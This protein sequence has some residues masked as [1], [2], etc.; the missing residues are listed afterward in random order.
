MENQVEYKYIHIGV[1]IPDVR[2]YTLSLCKKFTSACLHNVEIRS[3]VDVYTAKIVDDIFEK[4]RWNV[5]ELKNPFHSYKS[6]D[7][8]YLV[9]RYSDKL[10]ELIKAIFDLALFIN[11]YKWTKK[12]KWNI[13]NGIIAE[14]RDIDTCTETINRRV[15]EIRQYLRKLR[16][17]GKKSL[18]TRLMR[19]TQKCKPLIDK[20]FS[21]L[22]NY[23]VFDAYSVQ[24]NVCMEKA[25]NVLKKFFDQNTSWRYADRICRG[26]GSVYLFVRDS[27]FGIK[28]SNTTEYFN[29][30][31]DS[32]SDNEK[33]AVAKLIGA[34][35]FDDE[36]DRID[37]IA[38]LGLDKVTNQVF[39]HYVPKTLIFRDVEVCRKWI[40][41]IVDEYGRSFEDVELV[42]V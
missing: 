20:Y 3:Y 25:I 18:L 38:V 10:Y 40:L 26:Q 19:N 11:T 5:E 2:S 33:Y 30:F 1:G 41:G 13:V 36:V 17:A 15:D 27:I 9:Y 12:N 22:Y 31:F 7:R 28:T 39:L 34:K 16:K 42:E 24:Y 21:D 8:I 14:C 29:L 6:W 4:F 32:C 23:P 35:V 37:W